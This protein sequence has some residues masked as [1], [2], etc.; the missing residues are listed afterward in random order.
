MTPPDRREL[1]DLAA[2]LKACDP[3]ERAKLEAVM[4]QFLRWSD[5]LPAKWKEELVDAPDPAARMR[6]V[7]S[8]WQ[9]QQAELTEKLKPLTDYV[10]P[11]PFRSKFPT[12]LKKTKKTPSVAKEEPT[13]VGKELEEFVA[14]LKQPS[15][16]SHEHAALDEAV[17][18]PGPMHFDIRLLCAAL[19]EKYRLQ[20]PKSVAEGSPLQATLDRWKTPRDHFFFLSK[21]PHKYE[22]LSTRE[23]AAWAQDVIDL[24]SLPRI[25]PFQE[26]IVVNQMR[27]ISFADLAPVDSLL[28]HKLVAYFFYR[29]PNQSA[30]PGFEDELKRLAPPLKRIGKKTT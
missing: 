4:D 21:Y 7:D 14:R 30:P 6:S 27:L 26:G 20:P 29:T 11:P 18:H 12:D 2:A 17:K 24:Y 1:R 16:S 8:F 13:E 28:Y 5:C 25:K 15:K 10:D 22:G 9:K 23:K 19:A 3:A